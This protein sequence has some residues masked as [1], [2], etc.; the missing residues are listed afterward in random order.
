VRMDMSTATERASPALWSQSGGMAPNRSWNE[1]NHYNWTDCEGSPL[2]QVPAT[3]LLCLC[4][5]VGNG[6]VLWLLGFHIRRNPVATFILHL[7]IADVTFLLSITISLGMFY[8]L[9]SLCHGL[10]SQGVTT[11][12]NITILFSFTASAHLLTA[13]SAVTALSV[14]PVSPCPCRSPQRFPVLLCALLWVLSFLLTMSLYF[15]P[16]ALFAFALSYLL[17]VLT[18]LCSGL[19]LLVFL[20]CSR[21]RPPGR[22]CAVVL[23]A[24]ILFPFLTAD[25]GY[26]LFLRVF[27]VSVFAFHTSLPLACANSSVHP[28]I[29]FL[30]GSCAKEFTLSVSVA[31]QRVFGDVSEP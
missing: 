4:G 2:S 28:L 16:S 19:T 26:W 11:M 3:L 29:Y 10:G 13:F 22:L 14:L 23:L 7:A 24:V 17:S 5:L 9:E 30:S 15:H 27:D 6:A 21:K 12:L 8:V 31:F 1:D 18:L 25:F 20:C